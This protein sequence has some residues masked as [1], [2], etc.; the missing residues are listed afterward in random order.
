MNLQMAIYT[1]IFLYIYFTISTLF[2]N[3]VSLS[4]LKDL[5]ESIYSLL[6]D[7]NEQ[8]DSIEKKSDNQFY[9]NHLEKLEKVEKKKHELN[10]KICNKLVPL[11]PK[12]KSVDLYHN[13]IK[14]LNN[15][16]ENYDES[17]NLFFEIQDRINL[18]R[19]DFF[20]SIKPYPI[21][22]MI[23]TIPANLLSFVGFNPRPAVSNMLNIAGWILTTFI[24]LYGNEIKM[25][26]NNLIR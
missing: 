18:V 14:Y 19:Y 26:L 17:I 5:E 11:L 2:K 21:L 15:F 4:K 12:I 24:S 23:F 13:K 20:R 3:L 25:F 22:Q 1:F 9:V 7:T 10:N 16:Q 6:N 8:L